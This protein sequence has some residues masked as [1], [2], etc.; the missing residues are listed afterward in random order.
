[1]THVCSACDR[2][3]PPQY[4]ESHNRFH[5]GL[6]RSQ[7]HYGAPVN[8]AAVAARLQGVVRPKAQPKPDL[9]TSIVREI[10]EE[11]RRRSATEISSVGPIRPIQSV[12]AVTPVTSRPSAWQRLI[13]WIG[14]KN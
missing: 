3:V 9:A 10:R 4:Q 1:M 5:Q 7:R 11:T 6:T 12:A 8:V 13:R 2:W 14:L